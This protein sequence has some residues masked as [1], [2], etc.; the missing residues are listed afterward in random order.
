MKPADPALLAFRYTA[1]ITVMIHLCDREP[2]REAEVMEKIQ[3][4]IEQFIQEHG[5]R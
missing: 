4:H 2:G 3:A 5:K 1:P